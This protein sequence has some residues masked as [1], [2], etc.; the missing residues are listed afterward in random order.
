MKYHTV[1]VKYATGQIKPVQVYAWGENDAVAKVL[2]KGYGGVIVAV[3][4]QFSSSV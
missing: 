4:D 1:F 3:K 2:A